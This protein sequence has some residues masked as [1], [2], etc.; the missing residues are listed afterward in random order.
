M[1]RV[2]VAAAFVVLAIAAAPHLQL[3][4]ASAISLPQLTVD[5]SMPPGA[6]SDLSEITARW[7]EPIESAIRSL[8]DVTATRGDIS[9][10]S[11][12]ITVRFQPGVDAE[13]KAARLTSEL[14][15][16]RARLPADAALSVWPSQESSARPSA[17]F[18]MT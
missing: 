4:Y 8:G 10:D 6:G 17:Q 5:L 14:A 7:V 2:I 16:V 15:A 13:M 1:R 12:S 11:A 3:D 18:V 9:A